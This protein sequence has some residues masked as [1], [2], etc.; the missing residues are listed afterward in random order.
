MS[1]ASLVLDLE[2]IPDAELY[3]PPDPLPEGERSFPPLYACQPI[4]IGYVWLDEA[5][6]FRGMGIMGEG[7]DEAGMLADLGAFIEAQRPNVITW[8]GRGFDLPVLTLRAL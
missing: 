7:K 5:L 8:N 2:T 6:A 1:P 4:V 3:S